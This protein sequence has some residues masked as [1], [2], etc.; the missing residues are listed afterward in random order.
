M[1][2]HGIWI[3]FSV[4]NIPSVSLQVMLLGVGNNFTVVH[5]RK[6]SQI[7]SEGKHWTQSKGVMRLWLQV[8]LLKISKTNW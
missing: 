5:A 8:K 4:V 1:T 2:C 7:V 6:T 3:R